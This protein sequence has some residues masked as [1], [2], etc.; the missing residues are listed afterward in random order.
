MNLGGARR[1]QVGKRKEKNADQAGSASKRQKYEVIEEG[2][3][4]RTT[5]KDI[6]K[7]QF[8]RSGL[9]DV[10]MMQEKPIMGAT[11][12]AIGKKRK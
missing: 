12:K 10:K 5:E 1:Y 11:Q 2:W 9:D 3:D 7:E 6:R 4:E 8:L